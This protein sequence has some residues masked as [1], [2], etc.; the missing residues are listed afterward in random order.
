MPPDAPQESRYGPDGGLKLTVLVSVGR[1]PLTARSRRADQ[2]ARA[3]ELALSMDG[4]RT[5]VLHAGRDDADSEIALRGYLGMLGGVPGGT[6]ADGDG[7]QS[8]TLLRQDEG[9]DVLPALATA[10]AESAPQLVLCGSQA[11]SGESSGMLPYLLAEWLGWPLLSGVVALE[12]VRA[13]VCTVL[14]ALPRGQRRRLSV[15]LPAMITV[16]AAAPAPR[17][18]AFGPARRGC[19]DPILAL[20]R[21]DQEQAAWVTAPA[22]KRPKR[23]KIVTATSARERFRAAAAKTRG[24][25]GKVIRDATPEAAA[26]AIRALLKEEGVVR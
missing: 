25:G 4:A 3:L 22:R 1:H 24:G 7:V 16:D 18:S 9:A 17:P 13:G 21:F 8:V 19:I 11:E 5:T 26:E 20:T 6:P 12:H 14:Q 15:R 23:L 2:D 10:L